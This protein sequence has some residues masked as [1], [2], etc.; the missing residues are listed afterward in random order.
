VAVKLADRD[1][2]LLD[3]LGYGDYA[4]RTEQEKMIALV[5][6]PIA[7]GAMGVWLSSV[8]NIIVESR[9]AR[10]RKDLSMKELTQQDLEIMDR[11]GDG[12]VT[13][14][15]FLEFMLIAMNKIDQQLV[16]ELR[17]HFDRLDIDG[18]GELTKNDL[19]QAARA[20]L[21]SPSNKLRLAMYKK[22]LLEQGRGRRGAVRRSILAADWSTRFVRNLTSTREV[23]ARN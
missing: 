5:F 1:L 23:N 8:A 18:T 2:T 19:I 6:I 10:Y 12:T 11:D 15:E 17:K 7:V 20:K 22:R 13:R 21:K 9:S 4:P 14:A 16:E 3:S